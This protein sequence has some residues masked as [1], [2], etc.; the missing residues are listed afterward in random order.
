M[1]WDEGRKGS[2]ETG[3]DKQGLSSPGW[4]SRKER[5]R[6]KGREVCERE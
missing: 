6:E 1:R 2:S 4:G 3:Q 5:L